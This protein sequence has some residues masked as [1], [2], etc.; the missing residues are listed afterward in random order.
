MP[1]FRQAAAAVALFALTGAAH[2]AIIVSV[3]EI[4]PT[5]SSVPGAQTFNFTG[6]N[7]TNCGGYASCDGD[8][9]FLQEGDPNL[10]AKPAGLGADDWFLTAPSSASSGTATFSLGYSANY[11][12]MLWGS[13]DAYNTISFWSGG[14]EGSHVGTVTGGDDGIAPADGDQNRSV[15]VNFDFTQ[16]LSFDTIVFNSTQRA[17]ETANH[18]VR[19]VP[20][21]GTLALLGAGLLGAGMMRRRRRHS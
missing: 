17:F 1:G 20:E 6:G 2:S 8:F 5:T 16:G 11:F 12:G 19:A 9:A 13:V 21:P 18:A 3:D 7:S 15:F 10:Y 14:A 4:P